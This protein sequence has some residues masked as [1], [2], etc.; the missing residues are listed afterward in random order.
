MDRPIVISIQVGMP[1]E[2]REGEDG[3]N[4]RSGIVKLQVEGAVWVGVDGMMGDAQADLKNHGG[5]HRTVLAYAASHYEAWRKE[6]ERELPHGGFG[7]NMT[8]SGLT[9][10]NVC[11]GDV[12][13]VGKAV[14]QVSEPRIPCWK[15]P[16]RNG[17]EDLLQRIVRSGRTGWFYRTLSE[18]AVEKGN[19]WHLL[20]RPYPR[21][22]VALVYAAHRD[23]SADRAFVSSAVDCSAMSPRMH[24]WFVRRAAALYG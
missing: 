2:M 6:L 1:R 24:D 5:S 9:E 20:E 7:E 18:G 23:E 13:R 17:V 15:I 4:W 22:S 19:A 12:F 10:E 3:G 14:L 16:R 21:M 11:I 8:V